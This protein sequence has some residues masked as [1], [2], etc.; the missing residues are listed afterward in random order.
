MATNNFLL[1]GGDSYVQF[2]RGRVLIGATDGKFVSNETM[3]YIRRLGTVRARVEGRIT[4][5]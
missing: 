1:A 2:A 3:A 5:R 4:L